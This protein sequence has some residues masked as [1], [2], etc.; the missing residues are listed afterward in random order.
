MA[1]YSYIPLL[2]YR[3]EHSSAERPFCASKGSDLSDKYTTKPKEVLHMHFLRTA[4]E[5]KLQC[6][7]TCVC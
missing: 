4:D 1:W 2:R 5:R 6:I 3:F 7:C